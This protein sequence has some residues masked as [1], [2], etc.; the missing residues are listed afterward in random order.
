MSEP[1]TTFLDRDDEM[2][3]LLLERLLIADSKPNATRRAQR[4]I[5]QLHMIAQLGKRAL[6]ESGAFS[7]RTTARLTRVLRQ[8]GLA[9]ALDPQAAANVGRGIAT[10]HDEMVRLLWAINS[11][12]HQSFELA[13]RHWGA[14]ADAALRIVQLEP[15]TP[16][17]LTDQPDQPT[18]QM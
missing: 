15:G 16:P 4:A 1:L 13:D 2:T 18:L 8:A 5:W 7:H 14:L 17:G 9:P 12:H 6:E 10:T 11:S 3:D